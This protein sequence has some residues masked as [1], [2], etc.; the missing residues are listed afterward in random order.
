VIRL[1]VSVVT[2]LT[3]GGTLALIGLGLV[4]A[5]RA[6]H[7]FNFAHGQLMVVPAFTVGYLQFEGV[8]I[9]WCLL[10]ALAISAV[11]GALFYLFVLRRTAGQQVMLGIVATFGLAFI[12]DG[13]VGL[14]VPSSQY[15]VTLPGVPTGSVRLLGARVGATTLTFAALT[16]VLAAIVICLLRFTNLGLRVRAGGQD[17]LLASQYGIS[18]RRVHMGSWAAAAVLAAIA[19]ISY[20]S[21][22]SVT[23][24]ME[25][26]GLA[27]LPA[28]ILGGM[29]S[30]EGA[31]VGGLAI[32]LVQSFTQTYLSGAY[33]DIVTYG[34]LLVVLFVLPQGLFGSKNVVRA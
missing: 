21:V 16:L 27:A 5:Y 33:T 19:G 6:T 18:V 20:G 26:L 3:L 24:S 29:D 17:P 13:M 10:I 30:I 12:L 31:V 32:G 7:T 1:V 28:I 9:G 34:I 14:V 22:T 4:L 11:I 25:G 15:T 8:P 23:T 2:G